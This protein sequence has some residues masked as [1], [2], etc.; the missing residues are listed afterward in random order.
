MVAHLGYM[1]VQP[2]PAEVD[3]PA[4]AL[5]DF[6]ILASVY[7]GHGLDTGNPALINYWGFAHLAHSLVRA[8]VLAEVV[9]S[10]CI[11]GIL[12]TA[13]R[14][15][16][17]ACLGDLCDLLDLLDCCLAGCDGCLDLSCYLRLCLECLLLPRIVSVCLVR[18]VGWARDDCRGVGSWS[19]VS[20][21]LSGEDVG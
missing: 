8:L 20:I 9:V 13:V 5:M 17:L 19:L 21:P 2:L 11:G 6:L 14:A 4:S 18:G 16:I 12:A 1:A 3:Q 7:L 10:A 15:V